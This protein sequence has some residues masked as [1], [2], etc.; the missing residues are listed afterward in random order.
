MKISNTTELKAALRNGPYAWPGGYNTYFYTADREPLCH[1]CV[2]DNFKLVIGEMRR[3]S[4]RDEWR[5]LAIDI[6]Y[7]DEHMHCANCNEHIES[8]YGEQA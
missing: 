1:T 6:N 3:P 7:E 4:W 5:V 8:A 2:R